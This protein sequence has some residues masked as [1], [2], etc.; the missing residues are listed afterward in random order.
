MGIKENYTYQKVV[1]AHDNLWDL[2]E[3]LTA[4]NLLHDEEKLQLTKWIE[5]IYRVKEGLRP[6]LERLPT[7][8]PPPWDTSWP[9][10]GGFTWRQREQKI[11]I[12][13]LKEKLKGTQEE[14]EDLEKTQEK[15]LK[16]KGLL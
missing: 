6:I 14:L 5:S 13:K 12:T 1:E 9:P 3:R 16:N 8:S 11:K 10:I 4:E 7:H 15:L 2:R